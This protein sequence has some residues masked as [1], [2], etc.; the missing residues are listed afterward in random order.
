M[1]A[2]KGSMTGKDLNILADQLGK[3]AVT[4]VHRFVWLDASS[5]VLFILRGAGFPNPY[6][7]FI[8]EEILNKVPNLPPPP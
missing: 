6:F 3:D 7:G 5:E 1:E 4:R 2:M 8:W